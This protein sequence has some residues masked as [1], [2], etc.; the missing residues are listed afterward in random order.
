MPLVKLFVSKSLSKPLPAL[1]IL[2]QHMCHVWGTT[3]ATTKLLLFTCDDWTNDSYNE[4]IYI[5]I[6]AYGTYIRAQE[7]NRWQYETCTDY[8]WIVYARSYHFRCN[9]LR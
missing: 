5:D 8:C 2:Q 7:R 4:D 6:R 9:V 1:S 3:P